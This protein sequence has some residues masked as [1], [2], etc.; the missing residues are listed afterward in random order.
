MPA[1]VAAFLL[2]DA[3]HGEC[4]RIAHV[5]PG[6]LDPAVGTLG[7][8]DAE[9]VDVAVEGIGD[10]GHA[11]AGLPGPEVL[12]VVIWT[13]ARPSEPGRGARPAADHA[14]AC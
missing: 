10:A 14:T 5:V 12:V 6:G 8:R 7:V 9:L 13:R 3:C 11:C 2:L 4:A 1:T